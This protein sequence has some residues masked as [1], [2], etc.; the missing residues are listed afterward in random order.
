MYIYICRREREREKE[1]DKTKVQCL[2]KSHSS[3]Y[4]FERERER[5][6]EREKI[7]CFWSECLCTFLRECAHLVQSKRTMGGHCFVAFSVSLFLWVCPWVRAAAHTSICELKIARLYIYIY[8]YIYTWGVRSFFSFLSCWL[9]RVVLWISMW[10]LLQQ[11]LT[12][13]IWCVISKK[14]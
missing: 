3:S 2:F 14:T 7:V 1:R 10:V 9:H 11:I 6:R 4:K 12:H 8:I 5:E 13:S